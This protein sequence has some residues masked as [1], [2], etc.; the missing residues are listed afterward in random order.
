MR[1]GA[2]SGILPRYTHGIYQEKNTLMVLGRGLGGPRIGIR[3]EVVIIDLYAEKKRKDN[4]KEKPFWLESRPEG[5]S[6]KGSKI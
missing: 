5:V 1:A 6:D 4:L 2:G 3:P